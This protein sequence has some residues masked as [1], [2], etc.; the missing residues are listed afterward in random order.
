MDKLNDK[1][2]NLLFINSLSSSGREVKLAGIKGLL[3]TG[4]K[5]A[6]P[7]LNNLFNKTK[8]DKEMLSEIQDAIDTIH[9]RL[10]PVHSGMLS[11][12]E[13]KSDE[14]AL[15]ISNNNNTGALSLEEEKES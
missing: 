13:S 7:A 8:A 2:A 3:H 5:K 12:S 4:D 10:G 6:L 9:T 14:G 15:S 1:R 11:M